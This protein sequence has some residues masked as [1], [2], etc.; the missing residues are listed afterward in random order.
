MLVVGVWI[1]VVKFFPF[2]CIFK[3]NHNKMLGKIYIWHNLHIPDKNKQIKTHPVIAPLLQ[4]SWKT[5]F[6]YCLHSPL[7]IYS[8]MHYTLFL[9]PHDFIETVFS[10]TSFAKCKS[11]GLYLHY[12][13][14]LLKKSSSS[15]PWHYTQWVSPKLFYLHSLSPLWPTLF[16][17]ILREG[18]FPGF[19]D[20]Y[21]PKRPWCLLY[22]QT[23]SDSTHSKLNFKLS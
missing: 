18:W 14:Y 7:L 11:N 22:S 5:G 20:A 9:S 17:T 10:K 12:L 2:F 4:G 19:S 21:F 13:M 3:A 8:S 1:F 16:I 6:T 23:I 15:A